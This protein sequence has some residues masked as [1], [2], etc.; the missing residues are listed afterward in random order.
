MIISVFILGVAAVWLIGWKP[1]RNPQELGDY[2]TARFLDGHIQEAWHPSATLHKEDPPILELT[3]HTITKAN[4]DFY[5]RDPHAS[6]AALGSSL[7]NSNAAGDVAGMGSSKEKVE[8]M[9][10]WG[11]DKE[12]GFNEWSAYQ[13]A[14]QYNREHDEKIVIKYDEKGN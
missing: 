6:S 10:A 9:Q 11:D 8:N 2:G 4:T 1:R 7:S 14:T 3:F 5:D 13:W 12:N